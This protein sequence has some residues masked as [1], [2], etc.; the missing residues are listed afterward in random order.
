MTVREITRSLPLWL[1]A[2]GLGAVALTAVLVSAPAA[3]IVLAAVCVALAGVRL[4]DR[5]VPPTFAA[6]SRTVDVVGLLLAAGALAVLA[7][8]GSLT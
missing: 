1:A 5:N 4:V 6:R 8:A 7:P 2:G 3:A